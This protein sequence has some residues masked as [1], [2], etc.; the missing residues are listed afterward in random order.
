MTKKETKHCELTIR[1]QSGELITG[2]FHVPMNTS[3]GIRPSDAIRDVATDYMLLSRAVIRFG[4]D[5]MHKDTLLVFR[6]AIAYVEL[7]S[8]NW[9]S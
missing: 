5:S 6:S 3:S 8:V 1:L 4:T 2:L 7:P 9:T